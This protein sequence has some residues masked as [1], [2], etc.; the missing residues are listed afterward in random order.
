ML[1]LSGRLCGTQVWLGDDNL[2]DTR[3]SLS[4]SLSS[5]VP[6]AAGV[7]VEARVLLFGH[8]NISA[9]LI[10]LY[11]FVFSLSLYLSLSLPRSRTL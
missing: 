6:T 9:N 4:R 2:V 8:S 7:A 11:H 3:F 10:R 1:R 5:N